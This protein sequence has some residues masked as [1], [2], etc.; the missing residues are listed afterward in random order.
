MKP[1]QEYTAAF[2]FDAT[3][4]GLVMLIEKN[5]PSWQ[6][7][8]L[9]G[10]G[11]HLEPGETPLECVQREFH[12]ETG[13]RVQD[14]ELFCEL[15]DGSNWRVHFFKGTTAH[16]GQSMTDEKVVWINSRYLHE[17]D[18]LIPNLR[19]LIPMARSGDLY[20]PFTVQQQLQP[21]T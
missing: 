19:W 6:A 10:I 2:V 4:L 7:G 16:E 14:F 1:Q 3:N 9:N 13:V 20:G 15:T 8:K 21:G 11:G 5:R 12:E 18:N 17:I